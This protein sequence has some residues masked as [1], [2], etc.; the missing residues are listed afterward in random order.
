MKKFLLS[1]AI[2]L[3]FI[4]NSLSHVGHYAKY[5]YLEYELFRNNQSIG[6]HKYIFNRD[7]KNLSIESEVNFKIKKLGVDLYKKKKKREF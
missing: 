3:T 7:G 6:Y 4:L 2:Y 5:D 1:I